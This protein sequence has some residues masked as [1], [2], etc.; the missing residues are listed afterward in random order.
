MA[1]MA[2]SSSLP[3]ASPSQPRPWWPRISTASSAL[4][5]RTLE[6][7]FFSTEE[8][9]LGPEFDRGLV[10]RAPAGELEGALLHQVLGEPPAQVADRRAGPSSSTPT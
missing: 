1:A 7:T 3:N 10:G 4:S 6:P 8:A 5:C 2:A 9:A